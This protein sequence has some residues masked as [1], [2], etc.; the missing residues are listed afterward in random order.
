MTGPVIEPLDGDADLAGVMEI[1]QASFSSPWTAEMYRSE[2]RNTKVASIVVLRIPGC[3]VAGY[4]SYW[5]VVDEIHIN[6][7]AVRPAYRRRGYG[8]LIVEHVIEDGRRRAAVRALLEVR[9]ANSAA[10]QL[11]EKMGF[12]ALSTRRGYYSEP[13]DDAVIL[14]RS[15]QILESNPNA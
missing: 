3:R 13:V 6:N 14:C 1:D 12:T 11:Y 8:R 5:L 15:I 2:L 4:C 7:V 9:S 10:R